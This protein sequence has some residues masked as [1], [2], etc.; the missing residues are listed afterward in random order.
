M[1]SCPEVS[2]AL[3]AAVHHQP[4]LLAFLSMPP[5]KQSQEMGGTNLTT[6]VAFSPDGRVLAATSWHAAQLWDVATRT[7]LGSPIPARYGI[8]FAPDGRTLIA[9]DGNEFI[10]FWDT[11]TGGE[12]GNPI[13]QGSLVTTLALSPDAKLLASGTE[14]SAASIC[15]TS[16]HD[17][18]PVRRCREAGMRSVRTG[19]RSPRRLTMTGALSCGMSKRGSPAIRRSKGIPNR[20]ER[21]R[22]TQTER[23]WRPGDRTTSC[24]SG[25]WKH[26][27]HNDSPVISPP[28]TTSRSVTTGVCSHR[29]A[30][31]GASSCGTRRS[32]GRRARRCL[33]RPVRVWRG[34]QSVR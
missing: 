30:V 8:A 31:T 4:R 12:I 11:A 15:G 7:S 32:S 18:R 29:P 2:S 22:S 5:T 25:G 28:S 17:S 3:L 1:P 26:G 21:W 27:R 14:P 33:E 10:R 16:H 13:E 23:S 24:S 9:G 6:D 20:F 19:K 34:I